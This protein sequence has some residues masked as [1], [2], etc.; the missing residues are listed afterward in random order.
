VS[1]LDHVKPVVR[2]IGAYTLPPLEAPIKV[3]QNENPHELPD[4]LKRKVMQRALAR[5]WGRYPPFDP[6]ELQQALAASAGW[7]ADGVLV[8]NGSN[9]LIQ[10]LL[11]VTVG[12]GTPVVIPEPTFTL[13]AMVTRFLGGRVVNVALG[14]GL[15]YDLAAIRAARAASHAPVTIVCSPN[16]PTGSWLP[17]E[18]VAEL[19]GESDRLVVVDE[20]YHE[21]SGRSV[22]PLLGVHENL[23]VLRTFSKAMAMAGL[24]VGYL[25]ASP[26][27]VREINKARLPYNVNVVSGLAAL[28]ALEEREALRASVAGLVAER[29]RLAGALSRLDGVRVFPSAANF[30]LVE[31]SE[32]APAAAFA[33]LHAQGILVRDVSSAPRLARCLRVSVGAP[34]E[35]DAVI[36]GFAALVR[37]PQPQEVQP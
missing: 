17:P 15:E 3:N 31:L 29:E 30:L 37:A 20:A 26:A 19:C 34:A 5:P 8:G 35:N 18:D 10:A 2:G 1:A 12:E 9:E 16:N 33:A 25:M 23:I 32:V 21:F 24:R 28:A 36:A 27:L 14:P 13:Y 4:A 7:R 6:A 22:V 11:M